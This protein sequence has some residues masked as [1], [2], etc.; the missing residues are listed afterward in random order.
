M[1]TYVLIISQKFP[2]T[3]K[4][5]GKAT[6]FQI[7]IKEKIKIHTIRKNCQL[8]EKRIKEVEKGNAVLSVRV[9][10]GL[11]YRSKQ[12]EI[13]QFTKNDGVGIEKLDYGIGN[14]PDLAYN[15]GLLRQ[16][17]SDWFKDAD[18][19]KPL[20]IIHFTPFRYCA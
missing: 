12:R 14:Y 10:T 9:W 4:K 13:F 19:T 8:W 3:H 5:S 17:F 7:N 6:Y 15:D 16:D 1:K 20:A 18:K 2:K 11:P